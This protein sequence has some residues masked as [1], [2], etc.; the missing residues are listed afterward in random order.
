MPISTLTSKGQMTLPKAIREKLN[1]KEGDRLDVV[2]EH[3]RILLIP[4]TFH[5][6]DLV[7][8]LPK[9]SRTASL[10]VIDRAIRTRASHKR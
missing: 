10:G 8:V 3:D 9:P 1:L 5:A 2:L 4:V 7:S 6:L